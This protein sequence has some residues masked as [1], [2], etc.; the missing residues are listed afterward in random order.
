MSFILSAE[1]LSIRYGKKLAVDSISFAVLP[2][3]VVAFLGPNGAGKTSTISALTGL[4]KPTSGSIKVLGGSPFDT[5]TRIK[6]G[7]IPQEIDFP[8]TLKV[9]ELIELALAHYPNPETVERLSNDFALRSILERQAGGLSGGEKRRL[10]CALAFCGN[11]EVV[12]L[13]EPTTGLDIE[14]RNKLWLAIRSHIA[15]GR[16]VFL[17]THYLEEVDRLADEV[18]LINKGQVKFKGSSEEFKRQIGVRQVKLRLESLPELK[19]VIHHKFEEGY[20]YLSTQDSDLLV[21]E[22][23]EKKV[24]FKDLEISPLTVEEAFIQLV[25]EHT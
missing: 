8:K 25:K 10:A 3:K 11:P 16:T 1:N 24:P 9:R 17:T 5:L 12:F 2:G 21:R 4:L 7:C 23:V 20:F 22:L 18:I 15:R 19:N 13:D 14:S 6:I